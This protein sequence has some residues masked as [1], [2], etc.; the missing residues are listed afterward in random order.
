MEKSIND[1]L[2]QV[3]TYLFNNALDAEEHA[4]ITKDFKDI[5][6]NDMHIMDA[7]GVDEPK[8][9]S[10]IAK[11]LEVTMGT[12]TTNMNGLESKGYVVKEKSVKDRRVVLVR[13]TRKGQEAFYRHRD[14]HKSVVQVILRH[15]NE[16]EMAAL[17]K[18][19]TRLEDYFKKG[20]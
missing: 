9:M 19:L 11:A 18:C 6:L 20:K 8:S 3:L 15:T 5:S 2:E 7:V 4:L 13:L 10:E 1:N 14:Y 16:E 17:L 12:L